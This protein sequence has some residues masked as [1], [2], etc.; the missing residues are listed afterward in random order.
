MLT[1][2]SN[3]EKDVGQLQNAERPT[4]DICWGK[5]FTHPRVPE[6]FL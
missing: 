2:M 5:C 1:P 3:E 4:P 6:P